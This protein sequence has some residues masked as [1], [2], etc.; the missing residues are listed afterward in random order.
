MGG[1]IEIVKTQDSGTVDSSV[2]RKE[3]LIS[4]TNL[5]RNAMLKRKM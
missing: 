3:L 1:T 2:D 5:V 4:E